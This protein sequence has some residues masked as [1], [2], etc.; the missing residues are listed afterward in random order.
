[1]ISYFVF[2]YC[3][4]TLAS[5]ADVGFLRRTN[6]CWKW[7]N[8]THQVTSSLDCLLVNTLLAVRY[9]L[10]HP[11]LRLVLLIYALPEYECLIR[12]CSVNYANSLVDQ[13]FMPPILSVL[14]GSWYMTPLVQ[15]HIVVVPHIS[16][17]IISMAMLF[18]FTQPLCG[19]T[20][21]VYVDIDI[22]IKCTFN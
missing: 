10:Q 14:C 11:Y 20:G 3:M 21:A 2:I 6:D 4:Y 13:V 22:G 16:V 7:N 8:H 1:M 15:Y 12:S 5:P 18:M 9:L 17:S 19:F